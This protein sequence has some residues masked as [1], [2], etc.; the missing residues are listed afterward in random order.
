M[1]NEQARPS[2]GDASFCVYCSTI[3]IFAE[4]LSLRVPTDEEMKMIVKIP[5][6]QKT[7][8]FVRHYRKKQEKKDD[9]N[10]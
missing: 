8:D 4:D 5:A 6:F 9:H 10:A 3:L 2:P 1:E 7:L